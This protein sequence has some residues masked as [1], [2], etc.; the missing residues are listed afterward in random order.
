MSEPW[1]PDKTAVL[2]KVLCGQ[3]VLCAACIAS[4]SALALSDIE[5]TA[6]R[7]EQTFVLNRDVAHCKGCK[8]NARVFAVRYSPSVDMPRAPSDVVPSV[9]S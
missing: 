9:S 7:F 5:P 1:Q 6:R 4:N 8:R 2:A 3:S